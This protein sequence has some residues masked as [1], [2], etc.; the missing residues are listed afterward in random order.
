MNESGHAVGLLV[1]RFG[2]E[3]PQALVVVHDELDLPPGALQVKSGGGL[4]GHNGLR[5]IEAHL[6][7]TDFVR[8]RVGIGKPRGGSG[9]DH[10]LDRPS[11]AERARLQEA[12]LR[13]ADAVEAIV[14]DGIAAAMNRFNARVVDR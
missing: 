12:A 6:H 8:V 9:A 1:R 5:S 11:P 14:T 13:A 3:D 4:A 2:I 7:T 10:V